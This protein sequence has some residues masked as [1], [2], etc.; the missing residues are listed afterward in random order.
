MPLSAPAATAAPPHGAAASAAAS[1]S[2]AAL[3]S[4]EPMRGR[5]SLSRRMVGV[6]TAWIAVILL[7]G[8]YALYQDQSARITQK[9]DESLEYLLTAMVRASA[10]GEDGRVS[11]VGELGEP[12]FLEPSS[13]VYW[14]IDGASGPPIISQSLWGRVL[15]A[16]ARLAGD[17][18]AISDSDVFTGEP[19]RI[20]E[21]DVQLPSSDQVWRFR[22]A[23]S[24]G[25]LDADLADLRST[26]WRSF[27]V[28]GLGLIGLAALQTLYGLWPLRRL[29]AG[30]VAMR[31]GE[32]ALLRAPMPVEVQPVVNE[33]NALITH[34]AQQAEDAR[35]HAG[36]LAHALKTP[37]TVIVNAA[38]ARSPD[39][40]DLVVR[41]AATMRRQVDHHLA[42]AR[43]LG[44]RSSSQA[45]TPVWP[46]IEAV[47]RAVSRLYPDVRID[48]D[49]AKS[50]RVRM[51]RQDLDEVVGNVVENAAKYGGGSVFVTVIAQPGADTEAGTG[52]GMVDILVEDD[53]P[54]ITAE[55]RRRLFDRGVR[56]DSSKPGTGLGLAIVRDVVE[57]YGGRVTLEDSDDLGG[58]AVRLSIPAA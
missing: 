25:T 27:A 39:L 21:R 12:R 16:P 40:A 38:T 28:L 48:R 6:A 22:V 3:A 49:G 23:Q 10:V 7:L 11:I 29:R 47:E 19:V 31:E 20:A 32:D 18:I 24:R 42:R 44:R 15:K 13:G 43:A 33:L 52:T 51:E 37:L 26:L 35:R 30:I 8:G 50:R 2:A 34:N 5:G 45:K 53:G 56:L 54:G 41:E 1:V 58:L 46:S 9:V 55:D 36:N 17:E 57:L 4:P 14:Q